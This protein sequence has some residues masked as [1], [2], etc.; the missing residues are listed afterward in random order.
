MEAGKI[1]KIG[2]GQNELKKFWSRI[3]KSKEA[4]SIFQPAKKLKNQ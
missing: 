3:S 2:K 1:D 4:R